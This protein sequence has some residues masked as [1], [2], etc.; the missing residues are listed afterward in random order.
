MTASQSAP[1]S[2]SVSS[3]AWM[4]LVAALLGWMFDGAEMGV[5]SLVGRAAVQDLLVRA[6]PQKLLNDEE[7]KLSSE[8]QAKLLKDRHAAEK[9]KREPEVGLWFNIIMAG[10]LV[11]AATGGVV[12]GWLGDRIGRVRAMTLSVFTYAVFTGLCGIAAEA[13]QVGLLRFIAALGMGGEWSLGVA[14]VMEVWPNRSRAF[15]AGLIGAAA[16]VGYVLVGFIGLAL[17]SVLA[18]VESTLLGVGLSSEWVQMLMANKGWRIMMMLGTAPAILTFFIRTFVPESEKWE[19]E[20]GTGSTSNWATRDLFAVLLGML[21]PALIVYVWA[22]DGPASFPNSF[23]VRLVGT[24]LGL[25]IATGGYLYPVLRYLQRQTESGKPVPGDNTIPRMLLAA[26]L[27]GVALLGTWGST[28]Q[29]PSWADAMV[30]K[31][32][33][34]AQ[35]ELIQQGNPAA[36]EQLVRPKAKEYVLIWISVGAVVGTLIAALAGD[37]LGRRFSYCLLCFLSMLSVWMLF[38]GH[39]Q[40]GVSLLCW[41]FIAGVTTASFYGWL[42]LYLPELFRTNVRATGQGFGFNFGRIIAAVGVLQVGNLL[43][44]FSNEVTIPALQWKIPGGHPMACSCIVLI[45]IFGMIII[46]FAPETRGKELPE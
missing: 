45:Y 30:D 29:A 42:P 20:Q 24:L 3:A 21:G 23:L 22:W 34:R 15:M 14:L 10:F 25:A 17:L 11:G 26:C 31:E 28:Q 41:S 43:K 6:D 1:S 36:A 9:Q 8:E 13:W 44:F 40:Y 12:F 2:T 5:F 16:N 4:A 19:H 27:S 32:Y 35:E 38:L 33:K 37:W 46:W 18:T 39:T 7:R